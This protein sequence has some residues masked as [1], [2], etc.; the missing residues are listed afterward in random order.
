MS[1]SKPG[2]PRSDLGSLDDLLPMPAPKRP[3]LEGPLAKAFLR[4]ASR[5]ASVPLA[6]DFSWFM[7]GFQATVARY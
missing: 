6:K 1:H 5:A 3:R 4:S 7:A 2:G